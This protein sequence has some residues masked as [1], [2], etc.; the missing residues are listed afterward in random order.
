MKT[1]LVAED[2]EMMSKAMEFKLVREGY[3]VLLCPNG[4]IA[5]EKIVSENPDLIISDIMMPFVTG[6]D[7]VKKVKIELKLNIPI[8]MLSAVGLEKTVLEAFELGADD[9]ITKPF[10]PNELS[11]RVKRLLLK[12]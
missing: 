1:I 11:V 6:L 3:K 9:F 4:Q 12:K 10:S 8:I 7:I 2:D 5:L